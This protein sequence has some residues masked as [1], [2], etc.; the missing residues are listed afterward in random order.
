MITRERLLAGLNELIYVEEGMVTLYSKFSEALVSQTEDLEEGK[1]KEINKA[2]F[3]LYRDSSRHKE[4]LDKMIK[5]IENS[6][7]DE[8]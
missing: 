7:R 1:K 3:L 5:E 2:L 8:Y 4:M 6:M